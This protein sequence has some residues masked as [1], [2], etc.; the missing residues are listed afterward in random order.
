MQQHFE[1]IEVMQ[2][3][4]AQENQQLKEEVATYEAKESDSRAKA[5]QI[6]SQLFRH[7]CSLAMFSRILTAMRDGESFNL[8]VLLRSKTEAEAAQG[9]S[10]S[11]CTQELALVQH[12]F[13]DLQNN[14]VA[15]YSQM[16]GDTCRVC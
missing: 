12:A 9:S 6:C 5:M 3:A 4:M 11:D 13:E 7:R 15:W 14:A 1:D 16:C 8:G 10:L 2:G